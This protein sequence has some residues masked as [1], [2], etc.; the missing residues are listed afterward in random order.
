M[1]S[2]QQNW[3]YFELFLL[4]CLFNKPL[5]ESLFFQ[6]SQPK[7]F[8]EI[9][10]SSTIIHGIPSNW[11]TRVT[12]LR[13]TTWLMLLYDIIAGC[14]NSKKVPYL[15]QTFD[16]FF[17]QIIDFYRFSRFNRF[18]YFP[19]SVVPDKNDTMAFFQ[20]ILP[21][22]TQPLS[23]RKH[24]LLLKGDKNAQEKISKARQVHTK[25]KICISWKVV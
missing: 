19:L 18:L 2:I 8:D 22:Y 24:S 17:S 20:T 23:W 6:V 3:E 15:M 9:S 10:D 7:L 5:I 16:F 1:C 14:E 11:R 13:P 25:S 4:W 21:N 12:H